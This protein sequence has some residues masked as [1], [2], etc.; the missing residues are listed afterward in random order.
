MATCMQKRQMKKPA[1]RR[2]YGMDFMY[3][4]RIVLS[5]TLIV[6]GLGCSTQKSDLPKHIQELD[7]LA[8]YSAGIEPAYQI[9]LKRGQIFEDT[10][11]VII[12][13][14]SDIAI[15]KAGR[16][17][18]ADGKQLDIKVYEPGGRFLTRLG[19][20]GEGPGEFLEI[21]SI[22]AT[23]NKLFVYDRN[24]QRAVVFSID[25]LTYKY[26]INLADNRDQFEELSD[27]Y[28]GNLNV[29]S[30]DT[31]LMAFSTSNFSDE[32][33][34]WDSIKNTALFYNLDGKGRITSEKLFK[35]KSSI[36]ILIPYGAR[37]VGTPVDFTGELLT[38]FSDDGDIYVNW[39]GDFLIKVYSDAGEY[40][41]AFYYPF[42]KIPL[43]TET[44]LNAGVPERIIENMSSMD[45]SETWPALN[46]MLIDDENRLW[47]STIVEDF[48]VY[49]WWV[50]D[51]SDGSLLAR[52][53]WSR[54]KQIEK[55]KNGKLYTRET[56]EETGLQEIVRYD[57]EFV[58]E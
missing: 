40:K 45:L 9:H 15:D 33:N 23:K 2:L 24:Q 46:S 51:A 1:C 18:I 20:Q 49:Q 13:S 8:M 19:R 4:K 52:F 26:T 39:S 37:S 56:D 47:I 6:F 57:I 43:S 36:Q 10:D 22:Q 32:I 21:S 44:A 3:I 28:L 41:H 38:S 35:A 7:N 30:N 54:S 55:V 14:L 34:D 11:E 31:L 17:F 5:I 58:G 48:D 42:E 16:I 25:S 53:S 12:G 50:L 29:R 27:A